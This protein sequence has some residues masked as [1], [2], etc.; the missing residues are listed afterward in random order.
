MAKS[1]YM[2]AVKHNLSDGLFYMAQFYSEGDI[3]NIDLFRANQ[4]FYKC[5]K[6]NNNKTM[7]NDSNVPEI[8]EHN[9]IITNK[10]RYQSY[11][12]ESIRLSLWDIAGQEMFECFS[13]NYIKFS[14]GGIVVFSLTDRQTFEKAGEWITKVKDLSPPNTKIYLIGNK[15]DETDCRVISQ[16][17]AQSFADSYGIPYFETSA[18]T[19]S[20]VQN[21]FESLGNE[22]LKCRMKS[23]KE[24]DE[25][26]MKEDEK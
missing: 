17:E 6:I 11:N 3:I 23:E 13:D 22:I 7:Y 5:T 15:S 24:N 8:K 20:N 12:N 14:V 25:E 1:Y 19:G 26:N 9:Y 21:V 10:Y 18:K 16:S 2:L 4:Y